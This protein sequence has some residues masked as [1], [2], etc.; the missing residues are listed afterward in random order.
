MQI[1]LTGINYHTA[2]VAIRE[3]AAISA[4]KMTASLNELK[5]YLSPG[6]ILST[7]NRTEVYGICD[8]G[9]DSF[10][11]ATKFFQDFLGIDGEYRQYIY[12][13]HGKAAAQHLFRVAG[14][15]ESMVIGEYEV[16][17]QV[18]KALD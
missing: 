4:E 8:S 1:T 13:H 7:C 6:I 3:K 12:H 2:P 14:G 5:A 9:N 16:L 10:N 15:L 17:G 18:G 11:P